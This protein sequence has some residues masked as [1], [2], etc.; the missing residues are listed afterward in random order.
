LVVLVTDMEKGGLRRWSNN[1]YM[2][3]KGKIEDVLLKYFEGPQ[4][5]WVPVCTDGTNI[6]KPIEKQVCSWYDG[7]HLFDL[8]EGLPLAGQNEEGELRVLIFE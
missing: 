6:T 8:L 7:P 2:D 5:Q 1:R 4:I 3:L